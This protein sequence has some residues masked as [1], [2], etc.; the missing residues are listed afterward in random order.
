MTTASKPTVASPTAGV[1]LAEPTR[2]IRL[3]LSPLGID[4]RAAVFPRLSSRG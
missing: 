3:D 2:T 4:H 1:P